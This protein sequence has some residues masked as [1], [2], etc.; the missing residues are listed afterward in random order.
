[1]LIPF[2]FD[3]EIPARVHTPGR[4]FFR[5]LLLFNSVQCD[6]EHHRPICAEACGDM[7]P[8]FIPAP[9]GRLVR[10]QHLHAL[11]CAMEHRPRQMLLHPQGAHTIWSVTAAWAGLWL[12]PFVTAKGK[13]YIINANFADKGN[14]IVT[15]KDS[16]GLG[17]KSKI[18]IPLYQRPFCCCPIF[19]KKVAPPTF[20][21]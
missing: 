13:F 5:Y 18:R 20:L 9:P 1:M 19:F 11:Y 15:A 14:Y 17:R 2:L 10:A 4:Y 8:I 3:I 16:K 6:L 7:Q 21:Q 12:L